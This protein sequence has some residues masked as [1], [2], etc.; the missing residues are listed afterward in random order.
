METGTGN[1]KFMY[2][3]YSFAL[4]RKMVGQSASE[5]RRGA[6]VSKDQSYTIYTFAIFTGVPPSSAWHAKQ[7]LKEMKRDAK[8]KKKRSAADLM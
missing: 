2:A 4:T 7:A 5:A 1:L 6:A 8:G 3:D